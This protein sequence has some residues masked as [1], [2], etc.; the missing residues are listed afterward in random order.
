MTLA[1]CGT[2]QTREVE[3]PRDVIIEVDRPIIPPDSLLQRC[4]GDP[5]INAEFPAVEDI[6]N[7]SLERRARLMRC[8]ERVESFI[9][10]A[11]ENRT[12]EKEEE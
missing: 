12:V 1:A 8:A 4:E 2:Q 6:L 9:E 10:W 11:D 7:Q 3:V 5:K